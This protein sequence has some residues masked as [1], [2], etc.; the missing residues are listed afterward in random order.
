M[1]KPLHI[2]IASFCAVVLL[3]AFAHAQEPTNGSLG[4]VSAPLANV[5]EEPL[6]KSRLETQVLMGD[7]V[8]ILEKRD[9]RY[10]IAIPSQENR[11]G[12]VQQEAGHIPKDKGRSYLN[13]DRQWIVIA[14]PQADALILDKTG[15]HK[16]S[17]Y[18]GTRLPVLE[19]V[20]DGHKVQFP[21]RS[22]A[23]ISASE[24]L[25]AKSSDPLA[26]DT[27]P[28]ELA[29]T[30]RRFHGVRHLA[31]GLSAQGIDTQSLIYITYRVHGIPASTNTETLKARA[32]RVSK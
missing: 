9:N 1:N 25:P 11:E 29:Q 5:H 21:D 24:A 28:E 8:R 23:I 32:E 26:N 6:P 13:T 3:A 17:L 14:T 2:V 20:K 7:E 27:K 22:V 19:T 4:I 18:A 30:A 12:W 10:R 16:V 15:N 31:G